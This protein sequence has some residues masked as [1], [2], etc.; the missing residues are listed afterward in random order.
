MVLKHVARESTKMN[1]IA[2]DIDEVLM[3]FV[4]P[5]ADW[6]GLKMPRHRGYR[7]VYREMFKMTEFESQKMVREFY[8]SQAFE[9]IEPTEGAVEA[10][11]RLRHGATKIYAVTGRQQPVR[12]KTEDWLGLHFPGLFNDL[13]LTDSY[14]E[15]E[16]AKVDVCRALHLDTIIDDNELNCLSCAYGG[17]TA[18]HF[19][20][21]EGVLYPWC[22]CTDSSVLGWGEVDCGNRGQ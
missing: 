15:H 22:D 14:T 8:E 20:G 12:E 16:I 1:R 2:I 10:V 17:M 19:A 18:I 13:V 21:S 4:K 9:M 7:Y 3:P 5:M 11:A 6:R